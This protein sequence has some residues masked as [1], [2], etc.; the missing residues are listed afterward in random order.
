MCCIFTGQCWL[1]PDSVLCAQAEQDLELTQQQHLLPGL[2]CHRLH[3][4][5]LSE[6]KTLLFPASLL[7]V[8]MSMLLSLLHTL[9]QLSFA[10]FAFAI[11]A[12]SLSLF[13][14]SPPTDGQLVLAFKR[15]Q[16]RQGVA[17]VC[18]GVCGMPDI[19]AAGKLLHQL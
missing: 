19:W 1:A 10:P 12:N 16:G 3:T 9:D 7:L 15:C 6:R 8:H 11:A 2:G 17:E 13:W 18:V 4:V 5:R 14:S